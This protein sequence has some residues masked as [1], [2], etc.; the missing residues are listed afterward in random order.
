M[1][2]SSPHCDTVLLTGD[3]WGS[4]SNIDGLQLKESYHWNW[5]GLVRALLFSRWLSEGDKPETRP[6]VRGDR[7]PRETLCREK[8]NS[9]FI[10]CVSP[11]SS[12]IPLNVSIVWNPKTNFQRNKS[13][14][15]EGVW[16]CLNLSLCG[17]SGRTVPADRGAAQTGKTH[18]SRLIRDDWLLGL[19][20]F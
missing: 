10:S 3:R 9:V 2:G 18:L 15:W 1:E 17:F 8:R 6:R 13:A 4:P 14:V 20:D 7:Y 11:I 5:I 12:L 19:V 16:I